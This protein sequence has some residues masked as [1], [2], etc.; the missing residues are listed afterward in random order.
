MKNEEINKT[1]K[2]TVNKKKKPLK[3]LTLVSFRRSPI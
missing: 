3:N 1:D 2:K